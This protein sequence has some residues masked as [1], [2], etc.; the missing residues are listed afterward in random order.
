[1]RKWDYI[2]GNKISIEVKNGTSTK[3][4]FKQRTGKS[5]DLADWIGII[6]EGARQRG[7]EIKKLGSVHV[8][9]NEDNFFAEESKRYAE[10]IRSNLLQHS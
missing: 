3:P 7:F 6:I 5:P 8:E 4:G 2:R 1:M 10:A 9:E